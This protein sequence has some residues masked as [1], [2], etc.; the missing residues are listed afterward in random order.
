MKNCCVMVP[1]FKS[2]Q[3]L[4]KLVIFVG[5]ITVFMGQNIVFAEPK[6]QFSCV[7]DQFCETKESDLIIQKI[8]VDYYD[9]LGI[10]YRW[11]HRIP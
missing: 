8:V 2:S 1:F 7:V 6:N 5:T 3:G 10:R 4:F 9:D 11:T